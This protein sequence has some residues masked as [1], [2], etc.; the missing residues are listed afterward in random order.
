MLRVGELV[1]PILDHGGKDISDWFEKDTGDVCY[2]HL[3]LN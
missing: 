2:M 3:Q 1:K